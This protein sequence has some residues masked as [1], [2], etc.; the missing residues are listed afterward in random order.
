VCVCVCVCYNVDKGA[1]KAEHKAKTKANKRDY[2]IIT[3]YST[4]APPMHQMSSHLSYSTSA[5][6]VCVWCFFLVAVVCDNSTLKIE[7]P[8]LLKYR[9]IALIVSMFCAFNTFFTS[10]Y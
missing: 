4:A 6:C 2:D 1:R 8:Q 5:V 10:S 7:A 9:H 3:S